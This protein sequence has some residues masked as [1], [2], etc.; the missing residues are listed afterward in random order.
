MSYK[1]ILKKFKKNLKK[2]I[3][4]SSK[5]RQ[6][7]VKNRSKKHQKKTS[8]KRQKC[9]ILS[10]KLKKSLFFRFSDRTPGNFCGS[11]PL[12]QTKPRPIRVEK[13]Q[14]KKKCNVFEKSALVSH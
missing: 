7:I 4:K 12:R 14:G 6:K 13:G 2:L 9:D 10:E 3:K 11:K 1:K 8:K 5:N